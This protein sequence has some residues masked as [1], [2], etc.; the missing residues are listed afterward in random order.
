MI[1]IENETKI[2]LMLGVLL[3]IAGMYV[4][5]KTNFIGL[6]LGFFGV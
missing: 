2:Y 1:E 6:V 4:Q 5:Y 3:F